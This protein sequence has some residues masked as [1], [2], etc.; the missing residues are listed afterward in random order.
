MS[1]PVEV[2]GKDHVPDTE[3]YERQD[4]VG[5]ELPIIGDPPEGVSGEDGFQYIETR[6]G[7]RLSATV[8]FPDSTVYGAPPYPTVVEMEGYAASN[9]D[10]DP[11]GATIARSFGYATVSV[12]IRRH[13]VQWRC[14]RPVQ[15]GATGRHLRRAWRPWRASR[16]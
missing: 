11:P 14:V 9:P 8:R 2:L 4:L 6:D 10:S 1:G 7:V 3:L 5:V 15:R 16:G 12:N 13:R